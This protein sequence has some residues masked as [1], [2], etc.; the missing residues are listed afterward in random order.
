MAA[1]FGISLIARVVQTALIRELS[2]HAL[3]LEFLH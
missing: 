1:G 3:G 2:A